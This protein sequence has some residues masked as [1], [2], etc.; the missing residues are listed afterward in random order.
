MPQKNTSKHPQAINRATDIRQKEYVPL[1]VLTKTRCEQGSE[2]RQDNK[3]SI[4]VRVISWEREKL[5]ARSKKGK[6]YR[7]GLDR[8]GKEFKTKAIQYPGGVKRWVSGRE[9]LG[10][11]CH[12][13]VGIASSFPPSSGISYVHSLHSSGG[14]LRRLINARYRGEAHRYHIQQKPRHLFGVPTW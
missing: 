9:S 5:V 8:A 4:W 1:P 14:L 12:G 13:A 11:R 2:I 3:L 7:T 6:H 10:I